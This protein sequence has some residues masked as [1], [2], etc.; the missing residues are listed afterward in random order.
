MRKPNLREQQIIFFSIVFF[1]LKFT[2][3]NCLQP[4]YKPP[5]PPEDLYTTPVQERFRFLIFDLPQGIHGDRDGN[6]VEAVLQAVEQHPKRWQ[7]FSELTDS[8]LQDVASTLN[9]IFENQ[10][11]CARSESWT[12]Y[13]QDTPEEFAITGAVDILWLTKLIPWYS[14]SNTFA[15]REAIVL[16]VLSQWL[17]SWKLLPKETS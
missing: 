4:G 9:S 16:T 3:Q 15:E 1:W 12:Y 13:D 10:E 6:I 14:E 17:P 5:V 8:Q 2:R 7:F 11:L